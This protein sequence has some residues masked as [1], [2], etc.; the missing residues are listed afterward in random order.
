[1]LLSE[2]VAISGQPSLLGLLLWRCLSLNLVTAQELFALSSASNLLLTAVQELHSG[3]LFAH[4]LVL[5][6]ARLS[7]MPGY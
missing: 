4:P 1:V 5:S 7:P 3:G 6:C 2:L